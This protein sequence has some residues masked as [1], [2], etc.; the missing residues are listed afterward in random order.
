[1]K[2][3]NLST[4][5]RCSSRELHPLTPLSSSRVG[6]ALQ[7]AADQVEA[8]RRAPPPL[9]PLLGGRAAVFTILQVQPALRQHLTA[10]RLAG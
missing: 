3:D 5:L 6:L 1:M 9:A 8:L 7:Y 10:G 2:V 4:A